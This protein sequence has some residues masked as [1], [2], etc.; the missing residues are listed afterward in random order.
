MKDNEWLVYRKKQDA[1]EQIER[2]N[3]DLD[4]WV[5]NSIMI[6]QLPNWIAVGKEK[7]F[8]EQIN[9][10]YKNLTRY[11]CKFVIKYVE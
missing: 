8:I 9:P 6:E 1:V 10:T 5:N 2:I 7:E 4:N 3:A 11:V